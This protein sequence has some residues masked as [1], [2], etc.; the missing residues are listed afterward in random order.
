[1]LKLHLIR[2]FLRNLFFFI[3][4]FRLFFNYPPLVAGKYSDGKKTLT[5]KPL[6]FPKGFMASDLKKPLEDSFQCTTQV[7]AI[8]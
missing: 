6:E 5:P 4:N 1:M 3:Q 8:I 2:I 7:E